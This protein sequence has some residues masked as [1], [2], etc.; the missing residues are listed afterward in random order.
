M[1]IHFLEDIGVLSIDRR[2]PPSCQQSLIQDPFSRIQTVSR[3]RI[4]GLHLS[5]WVIHEAPVCQRCT[6]LNLFCWHFMFK[7]STYA[8][9]CY[10][11]FKDED[12]LCWLLNVVFEHNMCLCLEFFHLSFVDRL[13]LLTN[14]WN[15][16]KNRYMILNDHLKL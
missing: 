14:I 2:K 10:N 11:E 8:K 13:Y 12:I 3:Q 4:Q 5:T 6:L 16:F 15:T 9:F 1:P 7:L